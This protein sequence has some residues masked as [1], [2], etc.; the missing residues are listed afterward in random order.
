MRLEMEQVF[1]SVILVVIIDRQVVVKVRLI[2][3]QASLV[4][5]ASSDV[6]DCVSASSKD[7]CRQSPILDESY[8]LSVSLN[9]RVVRANLISCK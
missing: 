1:W 7:H 5:P 9:S 4:G 2:D 8:A 6:L 3:S